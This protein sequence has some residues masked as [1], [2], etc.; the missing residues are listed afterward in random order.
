MDSYILFIDIKVSLFLPLPYIFYWQ[1]QMCHEWPFQS[2]IYFKTKTFGNQIIMFPGQTIPGNGLL[3][4]ST[5]VLLMRRCM[6]W[7]P[8]LII[9]LSFLNCRLADFLPLILHVFIGLF[10]D[11]TQQQFFFSVMACGLYIN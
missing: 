11:H 9:P 7:L 10:R 6:H 5:S 1:P 8:P 2:E 4:G 3:Y